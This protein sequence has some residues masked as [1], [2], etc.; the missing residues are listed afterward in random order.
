MDRIRRRLSDAIMPPIAMI[1]TMGHRRSVQMANDAAQA[2]GIQARQPVATALA[3]CSELLLIE[4][5]PSDE[6]KA[7]Q[8]A[9]LCALRFT[10]SVTLRDNGLLLEISASLRLFGGRRALLSH[11]H[12]ALDTLSIGRVLGLA[13]T[14]QA[15]WLLALAAMPQHPCWASP[16]DLETKLDALPLHSLQTAQN[17]LQTLAGIGAKTLGDLR[18]LPRAGLARRFGSDLLDQIDRAYGLMPDPQVWFAAPEHFEARLDLAAR[19]ENAQTLIFAGRRLMAQLGGWLTARH[20]AVTVLIFT[21]HHETWGR[22]AKPTTVLIIRLNQPSRDPEHLTG[23]LGE[24]L[25]QMTLSAPVEALSLSVDDVSTTP[26]PNQELFPTP[27]SEATTLNQLIEKLCARLGTQAAQ[28]IQSM[29]DHRPEKAWE[30]VGLAHR[31][32]R[33]GASTTAPRPTWLMKTPQALTVYNHR[34][35]YQTPLA[36]LAGPERIEAGWWD[37]TSVARDYYVAENAEGQRLWVYRERKASERQ[38]AWY[39][40]GIFG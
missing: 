13:P 5:D 39:L 4:R 17:H 37:D 29:N 38:P 8:E 33:T 23:L 35:I 22:S 24:R 15:A 30:S 1:Q 2:K 25:G 14:A 6:Q 9:A 26:M 16:S 7:L 31:A 20:A 28:R 27:Q 10:P 3:L 34:P 32:L 12:Q 11:L 36:L 19:V 21:L 40:H 18:R